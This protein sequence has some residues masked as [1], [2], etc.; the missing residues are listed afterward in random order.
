MR[1]LY[2]TLRTVYVSVHC[3]DILHF[4]L[5]YGK[6]KVLKE[7]TQWNSFLVDLNYRWTTCKFKEF[8]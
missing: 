4:P 6:M 7:E 5:S 3:M 1:G 8:Q 2:V